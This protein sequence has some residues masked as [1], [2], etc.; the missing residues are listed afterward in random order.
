MH[1]EIADRIAELVGLGV[2]VDGLAG[3]AEFG[4]VLAE[5]VLAGDLEEFFQ[6]LCFDSPNAFGRDEVFPFGV[7]FDVAPLDQHVDNVG[8]LFLPLVEV[9]HDLVAPVEHVLGQFVED[10]IGRLRR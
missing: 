7:L 9:V 3:P 6:R 10:I 1:V 4:L 2:F 8:V 5:L